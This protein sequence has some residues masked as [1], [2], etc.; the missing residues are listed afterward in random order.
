V[1]IYGKGKDPVNVSV[2]CEDCNCVLIDAD[3]Y[4]EEDRSGS[5]KPS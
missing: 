1:A 5:E 3:K 4:L 2:E